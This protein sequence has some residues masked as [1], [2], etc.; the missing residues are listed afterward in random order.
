[1]D[2]LIGEGEEG[3]Y[4]ISEI[5]EITGFPKSTLYYAFQILKKYGIVVEKSVWHEGRRYKVVFVNWE[6]PTV[7]E[8][9]FH[10]KEMIYCFNKL[11]SR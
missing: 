11:K 2:F 4:T 1:L 9:I 5:S 8:L 3:G 7:R 10:F 6:D